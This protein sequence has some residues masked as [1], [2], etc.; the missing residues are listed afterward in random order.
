M[1]RTVKLSRVDGVL[2][3][4]SYPLSREE[5]VEQL[6]DV[7]VELAD[8]EENLGEIISGSKDDS[9]E[10]L[11]DLENEVYSLMPREA[12]GEPGQSEGEG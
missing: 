6:D 9:F 8:G 4:L 7:T 3:D 2:R 10:S 12:L 11:D 1:D 5:A